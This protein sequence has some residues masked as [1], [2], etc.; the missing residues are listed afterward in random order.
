M[1]R[2]W[3][4][5]KIHHFHRSQEGWIFINPNYPLVMTNI[6][7]VK[8]WPIEIDGLPN[9]IAWWIF[10]WRTVANNQRVCWCFPWWNLGAEAAIDAP[11]D[12]DF[13]VFKGL[14]VED[15]CQK[16]SWNPNQTTRKVFGRRCGFTWESVIWL[17]V[18]YCYMMLYGGY[19]GYI[20]MIVVVPIYEDVV[21]ECNIQH[22]LGN[23]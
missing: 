5:G 7:M 16:C 9:L 6:A 3:L 10:P 4:D 2:Q 19:K 23:M 8:P 17:P 18:R 22:V 13:L 20:Y 12:D 15:Y 14:Y 1:W 11:V 21:I